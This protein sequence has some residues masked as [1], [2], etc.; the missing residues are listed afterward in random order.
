ML[1]FYFSPLYFKINFVLEL[2]VF[3]LY[4]RNL[5]KINQYRICSLLEKNGVH[6]FVTL[7][8]N[9]KGVYI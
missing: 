3:K 1:Q 8:N 9:D 5:I 4:G 6:D 7:I 2:K